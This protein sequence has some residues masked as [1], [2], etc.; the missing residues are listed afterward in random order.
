VSLA[1][2]IPEK[3][4]SAWMAETTVPGTNS[5]LSRLPIAD[6]LESARDLYHALYTLNRM[7]LAPKTRMELMELYRMPVSQVTGQLQNRLSGAPYPL[8]LQRFK[9]AEFIRD[10]QVEMAYGYKLALFDFETAKRP[11][12]GKSSV[13]AKAI[14]RSIHYMGNIILRSMYCY[15]DFPEDV[16]KELHA[17]YRYA[18]ST[19]CAE[20]PVA[21]FEGEESRT[22]TISKR[23]KECLLLG[24]A[25]PFRL[26]HGL[27]KQVNSFV[28][29]W[30][31]LAT[32]EKKN[33]NEKPGVGQYLI[34]LDRDQPAV[35]AARKR[36]INNSTGGSK[37]LLDLVPLVDH[38]GS[39]L[40]QIKTGTPAKELDL[41]GECLE[42]A[43]IDM[44]EHLLKNWRGNNIRE[45]AR[46]PM[47]GL[48]SACTGLGAIHH[49]V[50]HHQIVQDESKN[51]TN[52]QKTPELLSRSS[53]QTPSNHRA[54]F[55]VAKW[56]IVNASSGGALVKGHEN[57]GVNLWVGDLVALVDGGIHA[58]IKLFT[59][60]WLK[61]RGQKGSEI[62]LE[63]LSS[64]VR[65]ILVGR[66]RG[67]GSYVPGLILE[68]VTVGN[69]RLPATL[70]LPKDLRGKQKDIELIESNSAKPKWVRALDQIDKTNTYERVTFASLNEQSR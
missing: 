62:G 54:G 16:W 60:R 42:Q 43:C 19:G 7:E 8:S 24:L 30:A 38:V 46:I 23:Y 56:E 39:L 6:S 59:V 13:R 22:S 63:L 47:N 31:D 18:E 27:C 21:E 41:G 34:D 67:P 65:P 3:K 26:P 33:D 52:G 68:K 70:I 20:E 45:S 29:R 44:L 32:I 35:S 36:S 57:S 12:W 14:F 10:I 58:P 61:E 17:L 4:V 11:V 37:H 28:Y 66:E 53:E 9:L 2:S 49:F 1:I 55:R 69:K 51:L 15:L 48:V 50:Y 64:S 5:W 25:G 40:R